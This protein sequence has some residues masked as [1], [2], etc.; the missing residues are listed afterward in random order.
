MTFPQRRFQTPGNRDDFTGPT[1]VE[2]VRQWRQAHPGYWRR[3]RAR[4]PQA[5]QDDF[6]PQEMQKQ[7]LDAGLAPPAL[8]DVV[9]LQPAVVVGLIA[10]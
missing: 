8:Q 2:R 1:H 6:M 7:L 4:A 3:Q 10:H 9:F 5:L